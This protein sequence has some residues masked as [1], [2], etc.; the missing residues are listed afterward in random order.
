MD[1]PWGC[2]LTFS[3][4]NRNTKTPISLQYNGLERFR[5]REP[6]FFPCLSGEGPLES[7]ESI[8][9]QTESNFVISFV[10]S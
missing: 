3:P 8:W 6:L 1:S 2:S 5:N 7:M 10:L 4:V 9:T